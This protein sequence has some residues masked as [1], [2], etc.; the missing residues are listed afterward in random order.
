LDAIKE[1]IP[2]ENIGARFNPSL[3]GLFVWLWI[4][5]HQHLSISSKIKWLQLSLCAPS[6]PFTDVSQ[7]PF[8]CTGNNF[9]SFV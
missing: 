7:I 3:D 1:V 5:I 4:K 2:Q 9:P 8:C 6:E